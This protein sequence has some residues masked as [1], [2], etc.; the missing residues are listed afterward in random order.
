MAIHGV[1]RTDNL[2][3]TDVRG[4][5][6]LVSVRYQ[7]SN[8]KT[9]IDNGNVVLIGDL[10]TN[11]R[12]V[13]KGATPA[14]NS[15]LEDIV[16]VA[17]PEIFYDGFKHDLADFENPAGYI[18]RAYHLHQNDTFGLTKEALDGA[19]SPAVGDTVELK[20]GTK[21]NVVASLTGGSTRVG[22]IIAKEVY[23][24]RTYYVIKV[25]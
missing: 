2:N 1:V 20:A 3:A 25:D 4:G 5:D 11:Q 6:N 17:S 21:L 19:S 8:T 24:S 23:P 18:A 10:E 14:A 7:P 13:Y 9:A 16:L 15:P 12:E 22:T